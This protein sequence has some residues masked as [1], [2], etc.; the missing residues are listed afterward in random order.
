VTLSTPAA[1]LL[2]LT[3]SC[4]C[5]RLPDPRLAALAYADAAARGDADALYAILTR[6]S[7]QAR[8]Q[9]EVKRMV[10]DERDEL[11]EQAKDLRRADVHVDATARVRYADGEEAALQ[12]EGGHYRVTAAGALPG[13]A[14]TPEAALEQLRR[15]LARRSYAGLLRVLSAATRS[16][17]E[18]DF[19]SLV[20]GLNEPQTLDVTVSGDEAQVPVPGGHHVKLRR[21]SGV[22]RIEDFD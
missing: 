1:F 7:R 14:S 2:V 6:A 20:D 3:T 13:G 18:N 11:G 8:S 12:L 22:W 19:R 21:D 9:D 5:A 10:S 4:T 15:V 17:V 16:S